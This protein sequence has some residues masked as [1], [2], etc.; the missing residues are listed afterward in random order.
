VLDKPPAEA[1]VIPSFPKPKPVPDSAL[2]PKVVKEP[3]KSGP[4][5]P[6]IAEVTPTPVLIPTIPAVVASPDPTL[7][8]KDEAERGKVK[9]RIAKGAHYLSSTGGSWWTAADP[10]S[11]GAPSPAAGYDKQIREGVKYNSSTPGTIY[12]AHAVQLVKTVGPWGF[13]RQILSGKPYK[14]GIQTLTNS[15][16]QFATFVQETKEGDVLVR[17]KDGK[18]VRTAKDNVVTINY[19]EVRQSDGKVVAVKPEDLVPVTVVSTRIEGTG[20]VLVREADTTLAETGFKALEPAQA[21]FPSGGAKPEHIH[22][23]GLGDCYLQSVLISIAN[24][25]PK[26]F[27]RMMPDT[28]GQ[29]TVTVNFYNVISTSGAV[30]YTAVPI[31]IEKSLP[32]SAG[33]TA[34]Y[35]QGANWAR[36]MQKAFVVFAGK[37]GQYG[38]AFKAEAPKTAGGYADIA[39]GIEYQLYGVFY[40]SGVAAPASRTQSTF[41]AADSDATNLLANQDTIA[42]L[43]QF[44]GQGVGPDEVVNLTAGATLAA[45]LQR[46]QDVVGL[47]IAPLEG[48]ITNLA[49]FKQELG[50][51][52]AQETNPL[53]KNKTVEQKNFVKEVVDAARE[54]L[55]GDYG[56]LVATIKVNPDNAAM[57]TL[58]EMLLNLSNAGTD[59]S[60]GQRFVYSGHAYAIVGA[61]FKRANGTAFVPRI[62]HLATDLPQLSATRSEVTLRNPHHGNAPNP[63]GAPETSEGP[64][65]GQFTL[66]LAQYLRNFSM[67]DYGRVKATK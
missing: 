12:T 23:T 58:L 36:L 38:E 62:D 6:V 9:T 51:A 45:H 65:A 48:T 30:S 47:C 41:A 56:P 39:G 19:P 4:P 34:L 7:I 54:F 25:N 14:S 10:T 13:D 28:P 66:S 42:K 46:A 37:F 53:N 21:L 3:A 50:K 1:P 64:D 22:Q 44:K 26:H 15:A 33:G 59:S 11:G 31:T 63:T 32:E 49:W 52:V 61:A 24:T 57:Q 35:N 40:G 43:L 20:V 67:L 60:K 18:P 16:A 5:E 2:P 17:L 29:K 55:K 8:P 27:E